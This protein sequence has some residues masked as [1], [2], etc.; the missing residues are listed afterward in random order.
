M[1]ITYQYVY[2]F[3][4]LKTQI[5]NNFYIQGIDTNNKFISIASY[6]SNN[7]IALS[8]FDDKIGIQND[9]KIVAKIIKDKN[10]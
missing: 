7:T 1:E 4:F 6:N 5:P 3:G 9:P 8:S 2:S 10:A